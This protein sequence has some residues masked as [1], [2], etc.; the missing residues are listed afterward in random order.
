MRNLLQ[1]GKQMWASGQHLL[2]RL[3]PLAGVDIIV[4]IVQATVVVAAFCQRAFE[5][6]EP[7]AGKLARTV[8]RGGSGSNI[9][10]LPD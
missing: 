10:S 8:L 4:S 1:E 7:C 9:A 2:G 3:L 5:R 6:L